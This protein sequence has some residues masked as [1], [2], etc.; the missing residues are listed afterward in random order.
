MLLCT[1]S[2]KVDL[3]DTAAWVLEAKLS[4]CHPTCC[5]QVHILIPL[6]S[7]G[8]WEPRAAGS[9]NHE[10]LPAALHGSTA[11]KHVHAWR[12][13]VG[14]AVVGRRRKQNEIQRAL[15]T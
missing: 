14:L 1:D 9:H 10:T 4:N 3:R 15:A 13:A 2:P 12:D 11:F 8:G 7:S 5:T 6:I